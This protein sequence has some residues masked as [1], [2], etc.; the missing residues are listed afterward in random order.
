MAVLENYSSE[1]H[2]FIFRTKCQ[3]E[4]INFHEDLKQYNFK[5]ALDFDLLEILLGD[6]DPAA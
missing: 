4:A 5:R 2:S 1:V 6:V 3:E